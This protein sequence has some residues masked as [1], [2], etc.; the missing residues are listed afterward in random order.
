M[1]ADPV[2]AQPLGGPWLL[3][4]SPSL[5]PASQ[6]TLGPRP[7]VS[8]AAVPSGA[9]GPQKPDTLLLGRWHIAPQVSLCSW[10]TSHPLPSLNEGKANSAL[11]SNSPTSSGWLV[12]G[13]LSQ[14]GCELP[15]SIQEPQSDLSRSEMVKALL[16]SLPHPISSPPPPN[17]VPVWVFSPQLGPLKAAFRG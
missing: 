1:W 6:R 15:P 17:S 5:L 14:L 16:R 13:G 2:R 11:W 7:S 10:S 3:C 9:H 12:L 8:L 4:P